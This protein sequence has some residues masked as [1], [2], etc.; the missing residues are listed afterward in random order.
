MHNNKY[1]QKKIFS[2][3]FSWL[4]TLT[5]VLFSIPNV[6]FAANTGTITISNVSYTSSTLSKGDAFSVSFQFYGSEDSTLK[7]VSISGEAVNTSNATYDII[8]GKTEVTNSKTI[9]AGEIINVSVS[10]LTYTGNG[11]EVKISV[12]LSSCGSQSYTFDLKTMSTENAQGALI[13]DSS[14]TSNL[15]FSMNAGQSKKFT[16]PIKNATESAVKNGVAKVYFDTTTVGLSITSGQYTSIANLSSGSSRDLSFTVDAT[17]AVKAGTYKLIIELNGMKQEVSLAIDNDIAPP[18]LELS[19]NENS[20]FNLGEVNP[21]T[22]YVKNVGGKEAKNIKV[23]IQ[24]D[25][26][27]AVVGN[28][29]VKTISSLEAGSST[30]Y[31]T[32][33][34][35]DS[36]PSSNLVLLKVGLSYTDASGESYTDTQSIYLNTNTVNNTNDLSIT[37]ITSPSGTYEPDQEFKVSFTISSKYGAENVKVSIKPDTGVIAKSQ[38]VYVLSELAAGKTKTYTVTLAATD[39]AT[40]GNHPIEI[41]LEYQY[42]DKDFSMSQYS[43]VNVYNEDDDDDEDDDLTSPKVILSECVASPQIVQAG[44]DVTINFTFLNTHPTK[45]V[46]NVTA[47]LDFNTNEQSDDE[48]TSSATS[49]FSTVSSSNTLFTSSLAPGASNSQSIVI[50]TSISATAASY[51]VYV[52]LSYQD[53]DGNVITSRETIPITISQDITID[54]AQIDLSSLTIGRST[55]MTAT[56]YNTSKSAISNVMMYLESDALDTGFS[57]TDNKS[58]LSSFSMG[59]TEYYA[60]TLTG[61]AAGTYDVNLVIEYEDCLGE[62]QTLRYPFQVEVTDSNANRGNGSNGEMPGMGAPN[63]KGNMPNMNQASSTN[64]WLIGGIIVGLAALLLIIVKII[65]KRKAMKEFDIHE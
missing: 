46:Y 5:L 13:L 28:S 32:K 30:N 14:A 34:Q 36:S 25:S 64:P 31:S 45:T 26:D 22:L 38:S 4:L 2:R 23:T 16:I 44:Q 39:E 40:T 17:T 55:A 15:S 51:N 7:S 3:T 63:G 18:S 10:G 58:Y 19:M 65:K 53:E 11:S 12:E 48:S 8:S 33:L 20:T 61:I 49:L 42:K 41:L 52:D 9:S 29:N 56:I 62:P 21:I 37:N 54:I 6:I 27:L 50:G 1:T 57:V 47:T 24:N 35:L 60:P 59:A 43:S